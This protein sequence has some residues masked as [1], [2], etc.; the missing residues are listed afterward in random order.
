MLRHVTFVEKDSTKRLL[1]IKI[2]KK[3]ETIVTLQVITEVQ[4]I[5]YQGVNTP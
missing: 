3:V 5:S 1:K 4:H 2:F